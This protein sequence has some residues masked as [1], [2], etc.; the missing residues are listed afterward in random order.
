VGWFWSTP[1]HLT[2]ITDVDPKMRRTAALG[3]TVRIRPQSPSPADHSPAREAGIPADIASQADWRLPDDRRVLQGPGEKGVYA[4]Y[5]LGGKGDGTFKYKAIR[6]SKPDPSFRDAIK[7]FKPGDHIGLSAIN[8]KLE[9]KGK[10]PFS[11]VGDEP[12]S[13]RAGELVY[14]RKSTRVLLVEGDRDGDGVA[15]FAIKVVGVKS[16]AEDD[17][18]LWSRTLDMWL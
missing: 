6:Q 12:L 7:D 8:K 9:A 11:F 5:T 15:D 16:L 4:P 3:L 18:V 1:Y 10:T 14:E 2:H 13:G 17:F